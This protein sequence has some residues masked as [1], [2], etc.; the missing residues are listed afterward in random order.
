MKNNKTYLNN[1]FMRLLPLVLSLVFLLGACGPA[2]EDPTEDNTN[3]D[4]TTTTPTT[5]DGYPAVTADVGYPPIGATNDGTNASA[6][7]PPLAT[8]KPRFQL[9][10]P[11][12]AG[13]TTVTG[14]APEALPLAIV[15]VS[16]GGGILGTGSSDEDGRFSITVSPLPENHRIG[17]TIAELE[18]GITFEELSE[19]Y[20]PYRGENFMNVPNIGIFYDSAVVEP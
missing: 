14:Q 5:S 18:E 9:D 8:D 13:A 16:F 11:L 20:F 4:N 2:D 1:P 7:P 15:D 17:V 12:K 19:Q 6:Y 3:T 10:L